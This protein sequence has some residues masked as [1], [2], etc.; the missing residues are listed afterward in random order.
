MQSQQKYY[1]Y[2]RKSTDVEDKQVLSIEAQL[3]ELREH[4]KREG[5]HVA[6]EF[7][8]KR[9]AKVMGR[10]VFGELLAEIEKNGGNILAWH[11]DR[12]AR[13]SVDGGQIIYLLDSYK[14]GT[15]KFPSFWFE[16]TSQGKFML[17]IAFGQSKYYVDNLSENTKR[18]L[19]QK[20]RRGEYPSI[21]PIGYINDIRNKTVIIDK[22]RA[23]IIVDAFELY[24]DG[25]KTLQDI[26]DFF[27]S[28][29]IMTKGGLCLHKDQVKKLLTNTFYYGHFR[30]GGEIH[31]GK[32]KAIISKKLFDQVQIIFKRRS[33]PQ[34]STNNPQILCGLL[35][36]ATCKMSITAEKK[37]KHQKNGN[38]HE[39]VYY[40]CTRKHKTIR[41]T[42]P[43]ITEPDLVAQLS[44]ILQCYAPP[45]AWAEQ[46]EIMLAE[47]EKQVE[48][49]SG[50]FIA[51]TQIRVS[52][53]QSKLQRLLDS[54]LDQDIDQLTYRAKQA[55]LMSDKKS[56]EEQ[57]GKLTLAD[58]A[59]V[60]PMR[61]WLKQAS[62][63]NEITKS[64]EH[65]AI[66][67][68]LLK[69]E[70]LNLFL[71][72]KKAQHAAAPE[73]SPPSSIWVLLRKTKEKSGE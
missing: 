35:Q 42:E 30:Y 51:D 62:D 66:K 46:L 13:N 29:G 15:L 17:S 53:L 4:A 48:R 28:K 63:L 27:K 57:I 41:C 24:A 38:R 32:H 40:R 34:K 61:Q 6:A 67:E 72:S 31:E 52:N 19:R 60:E 11:P 1:I 22:R 26:A 50:V 2:A 7:V 20:V 59:W 47:D 69:I 3:V 8:E 9:S 70:G 18:G 25:N 49:S 5:L 43:A 54:Y 71:K 64:G 45:K 44:D 68:A 73:I 14:L 39:Y 56:L 36:C 16:N 23:P 55:E 12:L 10:P 58:S 21:A 37:I 65:S 33:K